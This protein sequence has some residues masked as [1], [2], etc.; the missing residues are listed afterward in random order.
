MRHIHSQVLDVGSL[1]EMTVVAPSIALPW[2]DTI[3]ILT[4]N[5]SEAYRAQL[6]NSATLNNNMADALSLFISQHRCWGYTSNCVSLA[7][8][9]DIWFR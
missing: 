5:W 8:L 6:D 7:V 2:L 1:A 4:S 3:L 9:Y